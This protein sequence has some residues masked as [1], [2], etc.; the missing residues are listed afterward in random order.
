MTVKEARKILSEIDTITELEREAI[1]FILTELNGTRNLPD[2]KWRDIEGY[3]GLYQVSNMGRIK[4]FHKDEPRILAPGKSGK[5]Y[6]QI[7]LSKNAVRNRVKIHILVAR[8]FIPNPENKPIVH[9]K[10]GNKQDR[11]SS[12]STSVCNS[13]RE[14]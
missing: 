5:G 6:L 14:S 1:N 12:Q 3:E 8:A 9:H 7:S 10:F 4:S 2:E 13:Q 11:Q